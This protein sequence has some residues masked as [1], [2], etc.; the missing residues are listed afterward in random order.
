MPTIEPFRGVYYNPQKI[1]NPAAV[2]APPYDVIDTQLGTELLARS[3]YNIIRLILGKSAREKGSARETAAYRQA[4]DTLADWCRRGIL[5]TDDR[6]AIY[7]LE[8]EF[9]ALGTTYCRKGFIGLLR[10]DD[11]KQDAVLPHEQ[12]M[13]GPKE[14]RLQLMQACR[15]NFS[16]I[17][18]LYDDPDLLVEKTL[19]Q[20][21]REAVPFLEIRAGDSLDGI[22]RR[23][24]RVVEEDAIRK[25]QA[26]LAP[27]SLLIAD[28]HHR[29][30]TAL[31][32]RQRRRE[33][34]P[35]A[36]PGQP[37]D[38]VMVYG[39]NTASPDLAILPTHRLLSSYPGLNPDSFRQR[40]GKFF[41]LTP[42]EPPAADSGETAAWLLARLQ[43]EEAGIHF[44][45][46]VG[47]Q[48]DYFLLS[49][50]PAKLAA[51]MAAMPPALATMDVAALQH[52]LFDRA[53]GISAA[54]MKSQ[55]YTSFTQDAA[56]AIDAVRAGENQLAILLRPT[57]IS[58]VRQ[59]ATAGEKMPQKSTF[60]Y[61]KLVTGL[62]LYL[63]DSCQQA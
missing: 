1:A 25:V 39:T 57:S 59:V 60:F 18:T 26:V 10:L 45:A 41:Q 27:Q 63:F 40:A 50:P 13:S 61:P 62:I 6:P 30:E 47:R 58:Q 2:V 36:A 53:L 29:F 31:K 19:Q 44:I 23:L 5:V 28:G 52:L 14:D 42:L 4:A 49:L 3:P 54:D 48:P 55:R 56:A 22:S 21:R 12:T 15:A 11:L 33:Q 8:E 34:E 43:R 17:F 16:Q 35:D 46:V 51:A 38:F 20:H 24:W 32:Y 9:T 7:Y 37:Y